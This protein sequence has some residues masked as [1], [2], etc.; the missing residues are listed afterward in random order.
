MNCMYLQPKI[1]FYEFIFKVDGFSFNFSFVL[2]FLFFFDLFLVS[3]SSPSTEC[4]LNWR[5]ANWARQIKCNDFWI[6]LCWQCRRIIFRIETKKQSKSTVWSGLWWLLLLLCKHSDM[7]LYLILLLIDYS[8]PYLRMPSV[9]FVSL[10]R[11]LSIV[12]CIYCY[13]IRNSQLYHNL[14]PFVRWLNGWRDKNNIL[15]GKFVGNRLSALHTF[16]GALRCGVSFQYLEI[17][18]YFVIERKSFGRA[19]RRRRW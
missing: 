3:S 6:R 11:L 14:S 19:T 1:E 7:P 8:G 16:D 13:T 5:Q 9:G 2:F 4:K 17:V 12:S 15:P 18:A 10:L